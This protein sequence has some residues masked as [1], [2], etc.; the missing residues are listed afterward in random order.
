MNPKEKASYLAGYFSP[1]TIQRKTTY[2]GHQ[3]EI[4]EGNAFIGYIIDRERFRIFTKSEKRVNGIN[5]DD[6][7]LLIKK[8][9]G[10]I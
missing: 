8:D 7:D 1:L 2:K 3:I 9:I 4:H 5:H 10:I 6:I